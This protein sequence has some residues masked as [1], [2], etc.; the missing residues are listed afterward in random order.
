MKPPKA[1]PTNGAKPV[2]TSD[3]PRLPMPGT[4]LTRKYKGQTVR[5]T[6]LKDGFE[7]EGE[8]YASLSARR[9]GRHRIA[10]VR[11]PLL[12][13]AARRWPMTKRNAKA[14][15]TPETNRCAVYTRKSTDEGLD[16]DFSTLD[17]QRESGEAYVASQ[18]HEGWVCLDD[19]YD[20]G[21][22]SGGTMD[23]PAL[24]RLMADIEAG[25]IDTVV[26]YK[27]DRLSRSLLDF[28]KIMEVFDQHNVSF[29]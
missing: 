20:D 18:K 13:P 29:V 27:V 28:A 10:L 14:P 6:V 8:T 2:A 7:Y 23:R 21:G 19:R 5:V 26:V 17:A 25:K 22:Y 16:R 9:Q 11:L 1:K 4:V 24:Q 12:Q 3:D 15:A